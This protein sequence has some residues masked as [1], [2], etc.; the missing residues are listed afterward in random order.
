MTLLHEE[1]TGDNGPLFRSNQELVD[2]INNRE[3]KNKKRQNQLDFRKN[4][5]EKCS[6]SVVKYPQTSMTH[7]FC[8]G[9]GGFEIQDK[10]PACPKFVPI[11]KPDEPVY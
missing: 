7:L 5:C 10:D 1:A 2:N 6:Y 8:R 9:L 4:N 11:E 3:H